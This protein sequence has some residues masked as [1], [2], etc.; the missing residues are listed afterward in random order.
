MNELSVKQNNCNLIYRLNVKTF[1]DFDG[2][3][4]GDLIGVL[5]RLPYFV[6]LGVNTL[7]LEDVF[8]ADTFGATDFSRVSPA[9]GSIEDL[10]SLVAATHAA[11]LKLYL[12]IPLRFTSSSYSWFE[13]SAVS[14]SLNPYR[15]YYI[16]K[17]GKDEKGKNP[18]DSRKNLSGTSAWTHYG[19]GVWYYNLFGVNTPLLNFDNPRVRK[20]ILEMLG[21]WHDRGVDGFLLENTPF[22]QLGSRSVEPKNLYNAAEDLFGAED[23]PYYRLLREI[24]DKF[25]KDIS[26]LL[27]AE[28]GMDARVYCYLLSGETSVANGVI[29]DSPLHHNQLIPKNFSLKGFIKNYLNIQNEI[30]TGSLLYAF[31]DGK[32]GRLL[33]DFVPSSDNA[34]AGAKMLSVLFFCAKI[35]PVLYQGQEIGMYE[36]SKKCFEVCAR[37]P[38]AWDNRSFAGFTDGDYCAFSVNDN[39][40]KIN[41]MAESSDPESPLSFYR[42]MISF[43]KT[44]E[45]LTEGGFEDHSK[46][47]VIAFLRPSTAETL[48]VIANLTESHLNY[49]LPTPLS[50]KEAECVLSTYALVGK[51][52]HET[53]GL[54][55]FE[56]RIYR[57]K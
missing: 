33:S 16:W 28:R 26:V 37:S 34:F 53:I 40:R 25:K 46:G 23:A 50:T 36:S 13:K 14:S 12:S 48:L 22:S 15:E 11:D 44:S 27:N 18:P 2:D 47:N 17:K 30:A 38:F 5:N 55:P 20:E 9:V 49:K 6:A 8:E 35:T 29:L 41:M 56:A 10:E 4:T 42:K 54:R 24:K 57:V 3:G 19:N 21:V 39:Y 32:H 7:V 45:A 1:F 31:E 51:T 43:R 52:L